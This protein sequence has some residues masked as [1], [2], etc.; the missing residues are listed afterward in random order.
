MFTGKA[1]NNLI[2]GILNNIDIAEYENISSH[3]QLYKFSSIFL[4][5]IMLYLVSIYFFLFF[6]VKTTKILQKIYLNTT[7]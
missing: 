2:E 5:K 6:L 4:I 1:V 3:I 7:Y